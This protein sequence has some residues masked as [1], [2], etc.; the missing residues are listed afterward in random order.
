MICLLQLRQMVNTTI[1]LC[2]GWV[3]CSTYY[4]LG[5]NLSGSGILYLTSRSALTLQA[6]A[7]IPTITAA[8]TAVFDFQF[9][10]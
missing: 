10:G 7:A 6:I 1:S 2:V 4:R 8:M 3:L 5:K 9:A